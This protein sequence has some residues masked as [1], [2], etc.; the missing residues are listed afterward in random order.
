M[1]GCCRG[2]SSPGW[3]EMF[4]GCTLS[5]GSLLLRPHAPVFRSPAHFPSPVIAPASRAKDLPRLTTHP[6]PGAAT[7]TPGDHPSAFA[8]LLPQVHW[9]SPK[10]K[11]ARHLHPPT[12]ALS[13]PRG[14]RGA[15][16]RRCSVRL[17]LRPQELQAPWSTD[18]SIAAGP[19]GT[20]TSGLSLRES[21]PR[22]AGQRYRDKLGDFPGRTSAGW[23]RDVSGC[24]GLS[25]FSRSLGYQP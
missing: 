15:A 13:T 4:A 10:S 16:L 2:R 14:A 1:S 23:M 7:P 9:P 6:F 12:V 11:R 19:P 24:T 25:H 20:C 17:M 5:P 3:P 21:P 18:L 22:S 8:Q